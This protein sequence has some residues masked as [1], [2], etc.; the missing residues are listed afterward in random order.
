MQVVIDQVIA[1]F[2]LK[3]PMS[4]DPSKAVGD[5]AAEFA[6]RLLANY[7]NHLTERSLKSDR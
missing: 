4:D 1:K 3:Q 2:S 6:A 7:K 5:E